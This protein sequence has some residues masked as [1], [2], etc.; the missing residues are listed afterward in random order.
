MIDVLQK[1]LGNLPVSIDAAINKIVSYNKVY[2][3]NSDIMILFDETPDSNYV[4][5]RVVEN[6]P[7]NRAQLLD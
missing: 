3:E 7:E 2:S 5:L 6:T 4:K 1:R